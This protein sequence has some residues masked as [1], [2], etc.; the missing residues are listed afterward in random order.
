MRFVIFWTFV[1]AL[2]FVFQGE[3]D[4]WDRWHAKAMGTDCRKEQQ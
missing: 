1:L 2:I 3:P 4:L